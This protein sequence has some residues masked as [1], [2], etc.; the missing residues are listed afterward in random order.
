MVYHNLLPPQRI[1]IIQL[2]DIGDVVLATPTVR[3]VK[4]A[5]PHALVSIMVRKPCGSL[6]TADPNLHEVVEAE[7]VRGSALHV[8]KEH[9][10][11]IRRLRRVRY[12]LVIDLRTDDRG[13]I[14][15]FLTGARERVGR[16]CAKPFWHDLLFTRILDDPP[17]APPPVH[18]GA[19]QSLRIVRAIGIDTNDSTP[20]LHISSNDR[21]YAE[22]VLTERGLLPNGRWFTLNPFSRWKY[23]EWGDEKWEQVINS[24][25]GRFN[26]PVLLIGSPQEY[27]AAESIV[28]GCNGGAHNLTG[29]SVG[30]MAAVI[31]TSSLHIG[32]DSGAPHIAAALGIPTVTIHGPSD[33][34]AWRANDDLHKII[35]PQ[36]ECVPCN[37]KGCDDSGSGNG[38][39][40]CMKR[41]E[42]DAVLQE[43]DRVLS[44]LKEIH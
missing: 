1:L 31:A 14:M 3:A 19:D 37:K 13:A 2:G 33:W 36:M 5:Y 28:S 30:E 17:A 9:V 27:S 41:L 25:R 6:L 43:I 11:F 8:M 34:R 20:K 10:K 26:I 38:K 32:V 24:L 16:R 44:V 21:K 35:T 18:P 42:A 22:R 4:E 15:S 40:Q 39:S 12:D 29:G 7:T 23:K